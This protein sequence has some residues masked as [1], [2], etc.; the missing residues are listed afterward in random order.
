M[1]KSTA[2]QNTE[3]QQYTFRIPLKLKS[4]MEKIAVQEDRSLAKQII[5]ALRYFIQE[6][7]SKSGG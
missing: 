5:V 7:Q 4:E 2:D 3:T 6:R 1:K